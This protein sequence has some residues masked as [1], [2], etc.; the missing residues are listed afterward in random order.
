MGTADQQRPCWLTK[1]GG[2]R[3]MASVAVLIAVRSPQGR[4]RTWARYAFTPLRKASRR[5]SFDHA[6]AAPFSRR[7]NRT[8]LRFRQGSRPWHEW[9][10][11]RRAIEIHRGERVGHSL[12]LHLQRASSQAAGLHPRGEVSFNHRSLHTASHE[13]FEPLMRHLVRRPLIRLT[14]IANAVSNRREI[15]PR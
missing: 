14:L 12:D 6:R 2:M 9:H 3:S 7:G 15:D 8:I 13:I 11:S 1:V 4:R 5:Q 10:A